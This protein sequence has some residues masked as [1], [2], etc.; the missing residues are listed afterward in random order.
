MCYFKMY[1]FTCNKKWSIISFCYIL[2]KSL[3][4]FTKTLILHFT[5]IK[6]EN[7]NRSDTDGHFVRS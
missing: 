3:V 2:Y 6:F 1:I 5:L 4:T 7:F